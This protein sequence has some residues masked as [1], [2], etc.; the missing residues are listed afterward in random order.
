[1]L[2]QKRAKIARP[3]SAF[4]DLVTGEAL[5][6]EFL[7]NVPNPIVV[8]SPDTSI[9]FVNRAFEELTGFARRELVGKTFPYPY[10]PDNESSITETVLMSFLASTGRSRHETTFRKKNGE[11]FSVEMTGTP[12]RDSKG[13][14]R[15]FIGNWVDIT[16][17]KRAQEKVKESEERYRALFD[18][19]LD[20][21]YVHDFKGNF[22]DANPAALEKLGY[23]RSEIA[24]LNF[25]SLLNIDQNSFALRTLNQLIGTGIQEMPVEFTLR[26]KDGHSIVVET[27]GSLVYGEGKPYAVQG[28]ARDITDRKLAEEALSESEAKYRSLVETA[29]AGVAS[30]DTAGTITF[31]NDT[32]TRMLGVS[33]DKILGRSI[34]SFIHQDDLPAILSR[35]SNARSGVVAGLDIEFRAVCQDYHFIWFHTNPVPIMTDNKVIGFS[36]IL[37]DIT[38]HKQASDASKESE[39]KFRCLAEQSPNMIFINKRGAVIYA[40]RRCE[41]VT[42]FTKNELYASDFDFTTIIAPKFRKSIQESYAKHSR[43]ED[44]P[45]LEYTLVDKTGKEIEVI[46]ATKLVDYDREKVLMGIVTDISG[47]KRAERKLRKAAEEWRTTFDSISDL[48]FI[49]NNEGKIVRM[50]KAFANVFNKNPQDLLGKSCCEII[51]GTATPHPE[52]PHRKM[53]ET[54]KPV[55]AEY[56]EPNLD[57][58]IHE[59]ISPIVDEKGRVIGTVNVV[60]D[61]SEHKQIEEQLIMTDRLATIGELAA[62]IA[63]ELNNP[64]TGV[65][66]FSQLILEGPVPDQMRDDL[67]IIANEAQRAAK[68]VK[69]LLTF[70]RKHEPVKQLNQVNDCISEVLNIRAYEQKNRNIKVVTDLNPDLPKIMIDY[71]QMQ[72]VFINL[73]INAEFFM[74]EFHNGGTLSISTQQGGGLIRASFSDDGPGIA[75]EALKHLF[76]PFFTTKEVGKG[77]GLGLAICHGIVSEHGGKIYVDSKPG[78]GATFVV[79]LPANVN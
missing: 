58:Y 68:I 38:E 30:T 14:L 39:A 41:E 78:S 40:N 2:K 28:I 54:K 5:S 76:S 7:N 12:L 63:H 65:I 3:I 8:I 50:N 67:N 60:R 37:H 17:H 15:Y 13:K 48:V 64:L 23:D 26:C 18:R 70:A 19:S 51:H 49:R 6:S 31:I 9:F 71:F 4:G 53:M 52:C 61:I 44:T 21:V 69:N 72:Q 66:G 32:L 59:S 29:S 45:A 62:G 33:R 74:F 11:L 79:E 55:M 10:W 36:F 56:F 25:N 1:M 27:K 43:G 22:L 46:M 47:Q 34:T 35:L 73:I 42:G 20:L 57:M 16:R 24:S 77:T 75:Q